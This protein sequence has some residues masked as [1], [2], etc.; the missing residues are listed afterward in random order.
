MVEKEKAKFNF[1]S[2]DLIYFIRRR[3]VPLAII[4]AV[5]AIVSIIISL[6][7]EEKYKSTVILFPTASTSVSN[8]LLSDNAATK[9][10]LML[11]EEEE[12]EQMLQVLKSDEIRSR[13]IQKYNLMEHYEIDSTSQYPLTALAN[14]YNSNISSERTEYMSVE[15]EV[16]DKDP[17]IAANIANDIAAYLD[18]VMNRMQKER[19]R[20]AL[21]IVEAEYHDLENQIRTLE[22]SLV[23]LRKLGVYDY[24]S[25]SEVFND[26][27]AQAVAARNTA[28]A[29]ELEQKLK[30][31]AQYGGA[32]VS[33]RDFLEHEK[34]QLS[35]I[36]AKYAE[37]KVDAEQNLPHKFIVDQAYKA[38]RKS[39]PVRWLIVVVST[40]STAIFAL[41]LLIVIQIF[42]R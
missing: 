14:T 33:I 16:L 36:K 18:S 22:D 27:Y 42:R 30:V 2:F 29:K 15:I 5:G 6:T 39:Y 1:D 19:A 34:K 37:A 40:I 25:Q 28:G 7:I 26:A 17:Q 23:T 31:L 11:G 4:T 9:G 20:K 32:Y 10:V 41:L 38:E 35:K 3:F 12:V 21:K 24:E 13:I 8:A